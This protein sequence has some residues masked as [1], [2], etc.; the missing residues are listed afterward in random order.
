MF[1]LRGWRRSDCIARERDVDGECND[2]GYY[3]WH[4]RAHKKHASGGW[5]AGDVLSWGTFAMRV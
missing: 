4:V 3:W 5:D 2:G 1:G